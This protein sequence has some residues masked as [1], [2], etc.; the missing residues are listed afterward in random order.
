M[1]ITCGVVGSPTVA[2]VKASLQHCPGGGVQRHGVGP[3]AEQDRLG[4]RVH[5]G[6]PQQADIRAGGT[7]KQGEHAQ[8]SFMRVDLNTGCPAAEE[9][10]LLIEG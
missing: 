1:T 7:M 4:Y 2:M 3:F 6:D 9:L 5:V 10:T 8:Q